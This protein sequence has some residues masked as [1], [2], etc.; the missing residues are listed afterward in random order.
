MKTN[1]RKLSVL[2]SCFGA[3]A[4]IASLSACSMLINAVEGNGSGSDG[5]NTS[6]GTYKLDVA[7]MDPEWADKVVDSSLW[8][9]T[10]NIDAY[11]EDTL[12]L[13]DDG[14]YALTKEMGAGPDA[15]G[16][17]SSDGGVNDNN[18]NR[19]TY[20][21]TYTKAADG[22]TVTLSECTSIQVEVDVFN[23]SL[24][25]D[26]GN[27]EIAD[28]G[29]ITDLD[30]G[31]G[32]CGGEK[33]V[34][35]MYGPYIVDSGKGNC[36]QVVKLGSGTFTFSEEEAE[37]PDEEVPDTRPGYA[38]TAVATPPA[39]EG[40]EA[41]QPNSEITFT[42]YTDGT[43]TFAWAANKV[44][45]SGTYVWDRQN[46]TLTLTKPDDKSTTQ[47]ITAKDG[48]LNFTYYYS[49]SN[50]LFQ[51][52]EGSV[53]DMEAVICEMVYEM[54][55]TTDGNISL[56]L[57][58]DHTYTYTDAKAGVRETG[59]YDWNVDETLLTLTTPAGKEVASALQDGMANVLYVAYTS[60]NSSQIFLGSIAAMERDVPSARAVYKFI[61]VGEQH[62]SEY[63]FV[64]YN[65][66]TYSFNDDQHGVSEQGTWTF[67]NGVLALTYPGTITNKLGYVMDGY[68]VSEDGIV[69]FT[70]Y[71]SVTEMLKQTFEGNFADLAVAVASFGLAD[72]VYKFE[73]TK[74]ED[75]LYDFIL[76][77]SG[78]YCFADNQHGISEYGTWTYADGVLTATY[79]GAIT[80]KLGY[81]FGEYAVAADG[82]ITFTYYYSATEQLSQP[83]KGNKAEL[84][85]ALAKHGYA[86]EIYKFTG[87]KNNAYDFILYSNG[88]Y[89]FADNQHGVFEYGTWTYADGA[90][91]VTYP[92][93]IANKLGYVFGEYAV[94]ADGTITFTYYYSA[95][96]QLSQPYKGNKAELEIALAKHG[97]A[98]EIYKFTGTKNNAYDFILYSNGVY[99]FADNQHGVYEYGT[100]TYSD[101]TL[102]VTYHG[103]IKNKFGYVF[104]DYAVAEDDTISFTYYYS[105]TEQLSQPYAGSKAELE[106]AINSAAD[107]AQSGAAA[108][109][110][111]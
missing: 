24:G 70:Y 76:Y 29:I 6:D 1:I 7:A 84:E 103:N 107:G 33:V 86:E 100:W 23:M 93:T 62:S 50:Q 10:A 104:A 66:M 4:A 47:T 39:E 46:E 89:C 77:D 19:Y 41:S 109:G 61:G 88:V 78:A 28:T 105:V 71:Y 26:L 68:K 36:S 22:V 5:G 59:T 25:Y 73:C 12:V 82:T 48:K 42:V 52:Y 9:T 53:D 49:A 38:F 16:R 87:T 3:V 74:N 44:T 108:D 110:Q 37:T 30:F 14:T 98:E 94:V 31:A 17:W 102:S 40:G 83:Y 96:E 11:A 75:K 91:A 95:T 60:G 64:L 101:G 80:N 8:R 65:N 81:V 85:I 32:T 56:N 67:V 72:E 106:A 20:Y 2:I 43:Y 34:D 79:H 54:M 13:N 55:P 63:S 97:Y 111:D 99:C 90:L 92:G 45:D 27:Y 69:S 21:G 35:L 57:Y 18:F 51:S 58:G 15:V